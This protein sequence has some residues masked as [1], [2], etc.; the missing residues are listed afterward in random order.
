M[1]RELLRLVVHSERRLCNRIHCYGTCG[2]PTL[3]THVNN[4]RGL[5]GRGTCEWSGWRT[6]PLATPRALT[7]GSGSGAS[8]KRPSGSAARARRCGRHGAEPQAD[9]GA[10]CAA[11]PGAPPMRSP[12]RRKVVSGRVVGIGQNRSPI[13]QCWPRSSRGGLDRQ[14]G[15]LVVV[16][17][18]AL[19]REAQQKLAAQEAVAHAPRARRAL[20]ISGSLAFVAHIQLEQAVSEPHASSPACCS[21][22]R[23]VIIR[24]EVVVR[25]R[26]EEYGTPTGEGGAKSGVALRRPCSSWCASLSGRLVESSPVVRQVLRKTSNHKVRSCHMLACKDERSGSEPAFMAQLVARSPLLVRC[27]PV[28]WR[29]APCFAHFA[30]RDVALV[31][32]R[33]AHMHTSR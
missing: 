26:V 11:S 1:G 15:S 18:R 12:S 29:G 14:S 13:A 32:R 31:L 27:G 9:G 22:F 8:V 16:F 5:Q 17:A 24:P 28:D 7:D 19:A 4:S 6:H 3:A 2:R 21:R 20:Y 23:W 25:P 10:L 33:I 30:D